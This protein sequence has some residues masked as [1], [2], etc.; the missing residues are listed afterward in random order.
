M[1][2]ARGYAIDAAADHALVLGSK[3][4]A[5]ASWLASSS[6][7]PPTTSTRP[8]RRTVAVWSMRPVA[9]LASVAHDPA[10]AGVGGLGVT[11]G[12]AAP[13]LAGAHL[14]PSKLHVSLRFRPPNKTITSRHSS[15]AIAGRQVHVSPPP[16]NRTKPTPT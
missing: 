15:Y 13:P 9:R 10:L 1:C 16:P 3:I 7:L 2:R 11:T 12:G 4:S 5:V 8:S 14:P 6:W